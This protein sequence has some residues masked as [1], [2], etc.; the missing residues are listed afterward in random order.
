[1]GWPMPTCAYCP[2]NAHYRDRLRGEYLCPAHARLEVVASGPGRVSCPP[3][4]VRPAT[5]ADT[6][7]IQSLAEHFWGETEVECF[8]RS[9]DVLALP[10]FVA[11]AGAQVAG[12]LA[13]SMEMEMVDDALNIVL[14]NVLP[15]YQGRGG[16]RALLDAARVEA[17][18]AGLSQLLVAT[19]NDDLPALAHYQQYGFRLTSI[20]SG[21]LVEHHG[22]EEI[23]FSAIP[24]RDEVRLA[25]DV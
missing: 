22:G 10:A 6:S 18:R 4:T 20:V 14:L 19:S 7:A 25:C 21:R 11:C 12:V 16:A 24:V 5:P 8:G 1:M 23:G 3:L 17:R 15:D 9:Y 2:R 13:Y